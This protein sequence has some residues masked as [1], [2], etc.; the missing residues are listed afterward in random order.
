M[1]TTSPPASSVLRLGAGLALLGNLKLWLAGEVAG[2]SLGGAT[3]G[4][5]TT[6]LALR[7]AKRVGELAPEDIG[8]GR[9]GMPSGQA[10]AALVGAATGLGCGAVVSA[11]ALVGVGRL[12]LTQHAPKVPASL[13]EMTEAELLRRVAVFLPLDTVLPE[14]VAFRGVL[15][16]AL[17]QRW[18][19]PVAVALAAVP[20]TFWHTALALQETPSRNLTQLALKFAGYY[21]A[22]V[23]FGAL[24]QTTSA[25]SSCLAA[26]WALNA[27]LMLLLHPTARRWLRLVAPALRPPP[28][29]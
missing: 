29:A 27:T 5:A 23:G 1:T 11:M 18:P 15:L 3:F 21:L 10:Q 26:H 4:V 17:R 28:S 8:L 2:G 14:E 9:A 6:V 16:G 20:F 25:L 7:W 12:G 24:R 22:G 13:G 19:A